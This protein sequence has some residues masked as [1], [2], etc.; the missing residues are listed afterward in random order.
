[1]STNP[2]IIWGKE[3]IEEVSADA[4]FRGYISQWVADAKIGNLTKEHVLKVVAEIA[5]HRK[6]PSLVLEVEHRFG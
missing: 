6:D 3:W 4:A 2:N 5:D 1:M